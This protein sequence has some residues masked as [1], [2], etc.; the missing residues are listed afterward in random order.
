MGVWR[1]IRT[2]VLVAAAGLLA[3][4]GALAC[5]TV[6]GYVRPS[7][8]EL[9]Q[10]ADTIIIAQA[11]GER[12]KDGAE[13]SDGRVRFRVQETLKGE[14]DREIEV[15]RLGLGR[16]RPSDPNNITFSHPEGHAGPCN[17]VTV[18]KGAAYILFLDRRGNDYVPLGYP[19]SRVV[20]DYAGE[21]AIWT[22]AVRVYLELQKTHAP[23]AQVE[24]LEAM[25][26]AIISNP[27][28]TQYDAAVAADIQSHLGSLSPWKPTE[29]L[30]RA[31]EDHMAGRPSRY[32]LRD[33]AFD[34]EQSDAEAFA[35]AFA[36]VLF[37]D[38]PPRAKLQK[39]PVKEQLMQAFMK[40]DHP[41]AM[42]L[43]EGFSRAGAPPDELAMAIRFFAKNGRYREAYKLIEQAAEQMET[44]PEENF[45]LL[46]R[47][48][49]EAQEDPFY[50]EGE[51]RWRSDPDIAIRWPKLALKLT[52]IAEERFGGY[53]G[54]AETLMSLRND[55]YRAD[56]E[57]TLTLSGHS[58]EIIDWAASELQNPENLRA[59]GSEIGG[60]AADPILL[61]LQIAL[62]WHGVGG[63]EDAPAIIR[64]F[65]LGPAQRRTIFK[66]W[67]QLGSS[68]S[69]LTILRLA[70]SPVVDDTDR[71]ILAQAVAAW[72]R[73]Y[74]T[75][76]GESW[77][78]KDEAMQKLARGEPITAR[79]VTPLEPASC[80]GET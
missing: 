73:R 1:R 70:A 16:T 15:S 51:P 76:M 47:A 22:R 63:D 24:R 49:G 77:L 66:L 19:F 67:G 18:S 43:F 8:F 57:L 36:G 32:A 50:G 54:Y 53:V 34:K 45:F 38:D 28:R 4:V 80:G 37:G 23:M 75:D 41:A 11:I 61:P 29:F 7:N 17:R 42:P 62:R 9:V 56:P 68:Q 59:A 30:L 44:A 40:G 31:Y 64:V 10:I 26:A 74:Q 60:T 46:A 33:H 58:N 6:P 27:R 3:P 21:E 39:D 12:S 5:S 25:R 72:D 2:V 48:I 35:D 71:Q 78:A 79:D 69:A 14:P 65:C 52:R 20:E 55:D 13:W